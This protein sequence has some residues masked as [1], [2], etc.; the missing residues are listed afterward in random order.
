A[1]RLAR[2][3]FTP[4]LEVRRVRERDTSRAPWRPAVLRGPPPNSAAMHPLDLTA[5]GLAPDSPVAIRSVHGS[6]PARDRPADCISATVV[7]MTHSWGALPG[8]DGPEPGVNVNLLI[9]SERHVEHIN[10]M[11]R[12]TAIPVA[13]T[14]AQAF[15]DSHGEF[16]E[17]LR[18]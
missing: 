8:E 5:I 17:K 7:F 13:I 12:M 14:P 6:D 10:A 16:S 1:H 11:V 9:S 3:G 2:L 4:Q 18:P 15:R